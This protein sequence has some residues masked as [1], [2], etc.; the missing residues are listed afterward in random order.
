MRRVSQDIRIIGTNNEK[1]RHAVTPPLWPDAIDVIDA[2]DVKDYVLKN[3]GARPWD[4]DAI[5]K[6]IIQEAR[7][8]TG[9]VIDSEQE[10]GGYPTMKETR[11]RFDPEEWDMATMERKR[12]VEPHIPRKR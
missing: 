2:A 8:G 5:D 1:G 12:T 9:R 3:A 4:R 7:E 10:V 11:S 6:R